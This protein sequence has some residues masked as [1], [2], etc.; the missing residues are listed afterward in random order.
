M[1]TRTKVCSQTANVQATKGIT[2]AEATCYPMLHI[3]GSEM[4][5][6]DDPDQKNES[7]GIARME[8]TL[9]PLRVAGRRD[10]CTGRPRE[11]AVAPVRMANSPTA[12]SPW[13]HQFH[14]ARSTWSRAKLALIRRRPAAA[15]NSYHANAGS[16][17]ALAAG[18]CKVEATYPSAGCNRSSQQI[19]CLAISPAKRIHAC[20]ARS[21][22]DH[23]HELVTEDGVGLEAGDLRAA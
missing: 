15:T 5:N 14:T 13:E 2:D 19:G 20:R 22:G 3:A 6:S 17:M 4:R 9:R 16:S 7:C 18:I 8:P 10:E 1:L 12:P 11:G 21:A 23:P